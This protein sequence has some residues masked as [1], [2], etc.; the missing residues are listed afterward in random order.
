MKIAMWS[1]PRNLST[2]MMYS[3]G[4]RDDIDA[5]DEPFYAPY[6]ATSGIDHPM[7]AEIL[8]HHENDPLHVAAQCSA[9]PA[10]HKYMK[11][12]A[13]HMLDDFRLDW[14]ADC[15]NIHLLRHPARVLASYAA[16]RDEVN[17]ADIGY[18]QQAEVFG[19]LGGLVIDSSDILS[20]PDTALR[21]L[22]SEIGLGFDPKMLHWPAGPRTFDGIW[23]RHWYGTA[24]LSTGF[25]GAEGPLPKLPDNLQPIL[26]QALPIYRDLSDRVV[27]LVAN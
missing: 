26:E 19:K 16:K 10:H 24:H 3:F 9:Q 1:G 27:R 25:S 14:A 4:N 5:M 18:L 15:V 23:A 22:C 6:L 8:A 7:R 20:N 12:M 2:A 11:H 13:H 17:L 21:K